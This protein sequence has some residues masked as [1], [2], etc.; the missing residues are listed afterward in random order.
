[1]HRDPSSTS[2]PRSQLGLHQDQRAGE[3]DQCRDDSR[4]GFG[5][6]HQEQYSARDTTQDRSSSESDQ[7]APLAGEFAPIA[8]RAGERP[9]NQAKVQAT[10]AVTGA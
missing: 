8:V 3:H 4:E 10:F 5:G 2:Q 1:M 7:P 9:R 6:K